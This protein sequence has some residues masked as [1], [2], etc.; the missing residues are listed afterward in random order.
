MPQK[1]G[2]VR[3]IFCEAKN[4]DDSDL[5]SD[6]ASRLTKSKIKLQFDI[7]HNYAL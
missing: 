4:K 2:H 3:T 7:Y 6:N 1:V 5:F